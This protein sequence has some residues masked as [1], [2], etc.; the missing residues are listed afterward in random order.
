MFENAQNICQMLV[1]YYYMI[2]WL[3]SYRSTTKSS[4]AELPFSSSPPVS[5]SFLLSVFSF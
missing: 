4:G 3:I 1:K 2:V 5:L